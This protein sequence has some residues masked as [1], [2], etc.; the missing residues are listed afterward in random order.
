MNSSSATSVSFEHEELSNI[1]IG[2]V[3]V[4]TFIPLGYHIKKYFTGEQILIGRDSEKQKE[5]KVEN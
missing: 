2:R 1:G 3:T 5:S 4:V